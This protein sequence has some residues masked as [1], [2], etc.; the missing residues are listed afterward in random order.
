MNR[1]AALSLSGAAAGALVLTGTTVA[2]AKIV[3]EESIARV[4]TGDS[5]QKVRNRKGAPDSKEKMQLEIPAGTSKFFYYGKNGKTL[6]V[7]F[8]GG[9]VYAVSTRSPKQKTDTGLHVGSSKRDL[10]NDYPDVRREAHGL[11]ELGDRMAGF[12]ITIFRVA[13]KKVTE[14]QIARY[15]GE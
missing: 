2:Q 8:F 6:T 12:N 13:Q 5:V 1:I 4:S 11:Y 14:I 3:V 15:T 7:Q 10:L 9:T